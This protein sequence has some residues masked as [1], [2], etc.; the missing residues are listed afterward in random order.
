MSYEKLKTKVLVNL[1]NTLEKNVEREKVRWPPICNGIVH[2]PKRP[3]FDK[4]N[5]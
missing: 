1:K 3:N 5:D 2:Q 4:K